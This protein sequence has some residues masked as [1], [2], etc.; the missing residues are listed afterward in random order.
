MKSSASDRIFPCPCIDYL[1]VVEVEVE[2]V[3]V[4]VEVMAQVTECNTVLCLTVWLCS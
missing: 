4:E 3:V 1:S 2:V